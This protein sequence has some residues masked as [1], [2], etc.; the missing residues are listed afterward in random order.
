MYEHVL[1]KTTHK[2]VVAFIPIRKMCN[3]LLSCGVWDFVG[4]VVIEYKS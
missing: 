1:M 3:L 4:Q 2:K